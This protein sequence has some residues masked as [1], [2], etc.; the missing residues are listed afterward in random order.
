VRARSSNVVIPLRVGLSGCGT[1][2]LAV[3]QQL[4]ASEHCGLT[5]LHDPDRHALQAAGKRAGCR[6]QHQDFARFLATG[7]DFVILTGPPGAR[8]EQ[9]RMAAEQG[10]HCCV[11]APM[12]L[13]A[14]AAR[15]MVDACN[16]AGVRLGVAV[17]IL[18]DPAIEEIRQMLRE[19]WLGAVVAVHAFVG[20]D[21]VL[22]EPPD[23]HHWMRDRSLYGSHALH[24]LGAE[25]IHLVSWLLGRAPVS[26]CAQASTGF[27][28]LP[29]DASAAVLT[30]RGGLMFVLSASHLTRGSSIA[31]QGTDG[32]I[33]LAGDRISLRGRRPF[34]G[35]CIDY[36][37]PEVEQSLLRSELQQSSRSVEGDY[38]LHGR[39]ARWIEDRDD[40]PCTGEQAAMDMATLD[41]IARATESGH[42]ETMAT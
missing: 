35:A 40:F 41:L 14:K 22:R 38:E 36:R 21:R 26:A 30:L 28:V 20:E 18:A 32:A 31:I 12:A 13:D 19:D 5:A 11:H 9:V 25:H 10:A 24:Q 7:I 3:L 15:A 29:E 27:S 4:Q 6:E 1:R 17:P 2:G 37:T 39:F 34:S 42:R 23:A 8:L 33:R 16:A